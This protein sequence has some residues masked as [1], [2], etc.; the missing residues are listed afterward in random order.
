LQLIKKSLRIPA[1][2]VN[3]TLEINVKFRLRH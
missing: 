3:Y 2:Y 1:Q